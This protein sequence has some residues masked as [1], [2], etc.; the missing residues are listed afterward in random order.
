[1]ASYL[2]KDIQNR[3]IDLISYLN[4]IQDINIDELT[5]SDVMDCPA[6]KT[7]ETI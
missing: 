1:L 5:L 7:Q 6:D 3:I 2:S 4:V